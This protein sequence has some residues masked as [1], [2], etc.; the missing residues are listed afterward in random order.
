MKSNGRLSI[1]SPNTSLRKI[2]EQ[3]VQAIDEE[4]LVDAAFAEGAKEKDKLTK[5][6]EKEEI[7]VGECQNQEE[8]EVQERMKKVSSLLA[9]FEDDDNDKDVHDNDIQR[10]DSGADAKEVVSLDND[11]DNMNGICLSEISQAETPLVG[12]KEEERVHADRSK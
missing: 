7:K 8:M 10:N 11:V 12:V 9:G 3:E 5:I 1:P 2:Y 4:L 6:A